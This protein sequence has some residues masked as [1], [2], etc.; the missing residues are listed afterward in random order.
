MEARSI[1]FQSD[2]SQRGFTLIELMI[3]VTIIGVLAAIAIPQYQSYT[4]RS[5]W[6]D[7]FSAVG[8]FKQAITECM[9]VNRQQGLPTPPCNSTANLVAGQFLQNGTVDPILK[10]NFGLMDYGTTSSG[11]M[12]FSGGGLTAGAA[13]TVSLTPNGTQSQVAWTFA[14]TA[15]AICNRM[16]TGVGN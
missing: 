9:Q 6:S 5:R 15:P 12:S 3:V 16:L 13:C 8:R 10:P 2:K 11:V 1:L 4:V 14:N 7:N